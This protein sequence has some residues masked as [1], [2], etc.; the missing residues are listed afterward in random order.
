MTNR[1]KV[2]GQSR[3]H[4]V[5]VKACLKNK[6]KCRERNFEDA[7]CVFLETL[8]FRILASEMYEESTIV[9]NVA[10][11]RGAEKHDE[12]ESYDVIWTT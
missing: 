9:N 6:S 7:F 5:R 2:S 3:S 11:R 8:V 12:R 1:N 10:R 4:I